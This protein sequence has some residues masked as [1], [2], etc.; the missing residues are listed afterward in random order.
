MS[1]RQ[2]RSHE[3]WKE[4]HLRDFALRAGMP[5]ATTTP[6]FILER[7]YGRQLKERLR[8]TEGMPWDASWKQLKRNGTE[9][10]RQLRCREHDL[11]PDTPLDQVFRHIARCARAVAN[12]REPDRKPKRRVSDA[13]FKDA[14]REVLACAKGLRPWASWEEIRADD[15]YRLGQTPKSPTA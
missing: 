3:E 1:H 12:E 7:F 4:K 14:L 11:A 13:E 6:I 8:E 10:F 9:R 15:H 2:K 5:D